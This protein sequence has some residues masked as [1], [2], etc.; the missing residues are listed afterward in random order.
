[1]ALLT[2]TVLADWL[3]GTTANDTL[4]GLG[5][6]D[7]LDGGGGKDVIDGGDGFDRV[8][9]LS[10]NSPVK[11]NISYNA[12]QAA[13]ATGITLVDGTIIR[14]V[15]SFSL[16]TGSGNDVVTVSTA[17]KDFTWIANGGTD[18]LIADYSDSATGITVT[19]I[20]GTPLGNDI[21]IHTSEMATNA[22]ADAYSIEALYITGSI[23]N[24]YIEGTDGNDSIVGGY[25]RDTMVGGMGNDT[26]NVSDYSDVVIE[27]ANG[28][29]DTVLSGAVAY[30]LAANVENLTLG[31]AATLGIGNELD[32]Y[33]IGDRQA[34]ELDG[35]AGN[36]TLDGGIGADS[37]NGGTG[38]DT[39]YVDNVGDVIGENWNEGIDT[40]Y[41]S[42]TYSL[43]GGNADNLYL[44]GTDALSATGNGLANILIG[45]SGNNILNGNAGN[46]TLTGGAGAD[47][48]LFTQGSGHDIITDFHVAENDKID[49]HAYAGTHATITQH[50]A[51]A[52]IDFG[53]GNVIEVD[54]VTATDTAF[55]SHI[56]W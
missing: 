52:W 51:N 6:D 17:Q 42:V 20:A 39:Y 32:N 50:G 26:Y 24:D 19:N 35:N 44:T 10:Y 14:N 53:G 27:N 4:M 15:E 48:F 22:H 31:G 49:V 2:G 36:D 34:N 30:A 7:T 29:I 1:M 38:N 33:I 21:R 23:H 47:T 54:N 45:N 8:V 5:G 16:T 46:D 13:T 25:G 3:T 9:N 56:L 41:A 18:K 55:L 37:M 28:G 12:V 11:Q 40:V 43:A